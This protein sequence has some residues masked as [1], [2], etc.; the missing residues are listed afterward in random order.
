M[1]PERISFTDLELDPAVMQPRKKFAGTYPAE[2]VRHQFTVDHS[3]YPNLRKIDKW[4]EQN[5][6][7]RWG[8][9][10]QHGYDGLV[11][12]IAFESV[13]DAVMF[14]LKGGE[15]AWSLADQGGYF[16]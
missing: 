15:K 2:W 5:I 7:G 4:L 8:S 6:E 10:T 3:L 14:R 1:I 12:V 16:I 11:V 13:G 9:Y